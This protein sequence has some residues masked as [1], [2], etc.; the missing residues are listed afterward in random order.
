MNLSKIKFKQEK[1]QLWNDYLN[2]ISRS[3]L[4]GGAGSKWN[5][6][7]TSALRLAQKVDIGR[8]F[9]GDGRTQENIKCQEAGKED[10]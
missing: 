4:V 6:N 7:L 5:S 10:W 1:I 9:K 8:V 2:E 3:H